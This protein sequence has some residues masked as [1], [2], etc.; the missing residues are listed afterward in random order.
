M[1]IT[2]FLKNASRKNRRYHIAKNISEP[3]FYRIVNEWVDDQ[4]GKYQLRIQ[5]ND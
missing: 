1:A 3:S 4:R 5:K 2:L